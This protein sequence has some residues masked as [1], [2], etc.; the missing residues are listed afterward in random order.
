MKPTPFQ[1]IFREYGEE[2]HAFRAAR[3]V[4]HR[5]NSVGPFISTSEVFSQRDWR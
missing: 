3:A 2:K 1:Q 5:R 4:V